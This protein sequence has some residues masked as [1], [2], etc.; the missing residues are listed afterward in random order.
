M[1]LGEAQRAHHFGVVVGDPAAGRANVPELML[2]FW[3]LKLYCS[4]TLGAEFGNLS[5]LHCLALQEKPPSDGIDTLLHSWRKARGQTKAYT[6]FQ[7][8]LHYL[9]QGVPKGTV[10]LTPP[11][12]CWPQY[13]T[14]VPKVKDFGADVRQM[15]SSRRGG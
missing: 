12:G 6:E 15:S 11:A 14:L 13:I 1:R 9:L 4:S 8:M 2:P 10:C 3:N 5:W 7:C